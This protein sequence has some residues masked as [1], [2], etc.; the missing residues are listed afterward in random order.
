MD[1][2][3]QQR[4]APQPGPQAEAIAATWC[5]ELLYGGAAGGGKALSLD[6]PIATPHGW[7]PIGELQPGDA[8]FDE[9]GTPCKVVAVSRVMHNRP[10]WRLTF[11][12]GAE[13][14]ADAQHQ[15]ATFTAAER[16]QLHSRTE[17]FRAK[18]REGRPSRAKAVS[19][20]PGVSVSV[21]ALNRARV[22]SYELPPTGSLRTTEEIAQ[23]LWDGRHRNHAVAVAGPLQCA[24]A[25]L[26][27]D[28]YALGVWLGDGSSYRADVTSVDTEIVA[29]LATAG[30]AIRRRPKTPITFGVG[31]LKTALVRLS[32]IG[33]K[34][35]PPVYLRA[36]VS[37]RLSL[38]QGLM[39]TDG[40]CNMRGHCEFSVVRKQLADGLFELLASL[41]IKAALVEGRATLNGRVI[42]PKYT[43]KFLTEMQAFRLPR[44][45]LRQK[46]G[47][48]RGTHGRRYIVAAEPIASVPVR[49]IQ[50]D[51]P[52]HLYLAGRQ[53]I[54]T[55]NSD[56]LLG[57]YLQDVPTYAESW[58]GVL[59]RRTYRELEELIT[60]S[61]ELYP[62]TG[63]VWEASKDRW[64]WPN[65]AMLR[66]RYLERDVDA[67]RY[68][69]HSYS[70]IGYDELGQFP[71]PYA[72]RYL[73]SPCPRNA[74]ALRQIQA[75]RAPLAQSHVH[76]PRAAGVPA[77]HGPRDRRREHVRPVRLTDNQ[78]LLGADPH[79]AMRLKGMGSPELVRAMLEG[80]WSRHRRQRSS[81]VQ[82]RSTSSP[83]SRL[84]SIG[85]GSAAMDWGSARPFAV[86]WWAQVAGRHGPEGRTGKIP[87]V[88]WQRRASRTW[89]CA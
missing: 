78:I 80:D 17:A 42:G 52:S 54:P 83:C 9:N 10:C 36:S 67:T 64:I 24:E 26:P 61:L 69:G 62:Q 7:T 32:L 13:I 77:A 2:E 45:L 39:D 56:F 18:R 60:R 50:V 19:L 59:F 34:H 43:L 53:M 23:T 27:I 55:H 21:T 3:P 74:S 16:N 8:V 68:Q 58:Q 81:R 22:H 86:G 87:R 25:D 15:W 31:G 40:H 82:G 75:G 38:L 46:R 65:G 6:T 5:Q 29:E 35:I 11:S 48:F 1:T 70:W 71:S 76:R 84:P 57:D 47:Q 37:Q 63:G 66:L 72:Y 41:G 33:N 79:Y 4:W 49:C 89:A 20:K 85:C 73:P 51:S 28:P 44:K 30:H 14:I 12:D 88:V